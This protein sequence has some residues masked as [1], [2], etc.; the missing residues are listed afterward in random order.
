M[1]AVYT[2]VVYRIA[3][4]QRDTTFDFVTYGAAAA[5]VEAAAKQQAADWISK[6]PGPFEIKRTRTAPIA[7]Y[8]LTEE[9]R[10]PHCWNE[11]SALLQE[12]TFDEEVAFGLGSRGAMYLSGNGTI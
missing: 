3:G 5:D 4:Q 9:G 6:G 7:D 12:R 2:E 8:L 11:I 10:R 1:A